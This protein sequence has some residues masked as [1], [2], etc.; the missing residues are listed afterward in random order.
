MTVETSVV[1]YGTVPAATITEVDGHKHVA[2]QTQRGPQGPGYTIKGNAYATL[3]ALEAAVPNPAEGDQ[4]N[5][6]SAA[7]YHVYRW[8]GGIWEDQ[9]E[10]QG[11]K[12]DRGVTFTPA[13]SS[14][15]ELSFTN[16]GGVANPTP[17]NLA[18]AAAAVV[19]AVRFDV[20]Q[21]SDYAATEKARARANMGA[22]KAT[23]GTV[24]LPTS[25][26]SGTGPYTYAASLAVVTA[27]NLL[28]VA[29]APAGKA[30]YEDCGAYAS[31]QAAGQLTFTVTSVPTEEIPVNV[32]VI[33]P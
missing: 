3:A 9:G 1:P 15:G 25:G 23:P 6:G 12:G 4:Y 16:D 30:A 2:I 8:T 17:V 18:Q 14:G 5:V 13:V 20:D 11:P 26:W 21:S 22:A 29:P 19:P 33:D 24:T 27:S 31:A 7:P 28:I 32:M 10:L